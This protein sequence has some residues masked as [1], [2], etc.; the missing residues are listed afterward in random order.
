MIR[1]LS[2]DSTVFKEEKLYSF[3]YGQLSDDRRAHVDACRMAADRRLRL[4]AGVLLH[5]AL[6]DLGLRECDMRYTVEKN[7]KPCFASDIPLNFSI[8]HADPYVILALSDREVGCD[9]E[10]IRPVSTDIA[11]RFFCLEEYEAI[12]AVSDMTER[13]HTFFRLWTMKESF[14]KI[15]G[16]GFR[17]SMKRFSLDL[18]HTPVTATGDFGAEQYF[19]HEY[20]EDGKNKSRGDGFPGFCMT[21]CTVRS[22]QRPIHE[23]LDD[24]V[25]W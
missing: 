23:R 15:T 18:S 14:L 17:L 4:G 8:S 2:L 11:G 1:L 5:L 6:D 13:L 9:V 25:L 24:R 7:G 21:C 10:R 19:F 22:V 16:E 12:M 3:W 20:E